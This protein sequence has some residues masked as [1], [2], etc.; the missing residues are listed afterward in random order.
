MTLSLIR[1]PSVGESVTEVSLLKWLKKSGEQVQAGEP[2][3]EIESDK[4]TVE[5]TADLTG[6]LE[7]QVPAGTRVQV[8]QA[9]GKIE[10]GSVSVKAPEQSSPSIA[11]APTPSFE[12][13]PTPGPAARKLSQ[14]RQPSLNPSSLVGS[15]KEGRLTKADI[16]KTSPQETPPI[17]PPSPALHKKEEGTRRVPMSALR[18]KIAERLVQAQSTAAILT[19]FNEIDLSAVIQLRNSKKEAFLAKHQVPLSFMSFF[20]FACLEAL[21]AIPEVNAS[22]EGTEILYHDFYNIGIAVGTER[23][24]VVPVVKG[25][26]QLS[27]VGFERELARLTAKARTGKLSISEMTGGTFTLSN[28]GVYGSLLSTPILNPPQSGILGMHKIQERPIAREGRVEIR[29]MMYVALSYDHRLIDGKG[30]VTFLV[31][32]KEKLEHPESLS[33]NWEGA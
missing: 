6:I 2:L 28:G 7:I 24:L 11:P 27:I 4:A 14:E 19:T 5:V 13:G 10:E 33:F 3:L 15:G 18:A 31:L 21:K 30:A 23:G 9:L 1:T 26:D 12:L 29:P 16:L 25:V 32:V 20:T 22:I 8:G 17:L